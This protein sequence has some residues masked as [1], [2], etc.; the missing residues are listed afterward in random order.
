MNYQAV[1][2]PNPLTPCIPVTFDP[3]ACIGCNTCVDVCRTDVLMPNPQPGNPPVVV[4]SDE[5]WF[6]GCCVEDCPQEACEFHHPLNQQIAWKRKTTGEVFRVGIKNL[7]P[8]SKK[9]LY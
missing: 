5:C 9:K 6:C 7:P 2:R 1:L 4:Y 3:E 8:P